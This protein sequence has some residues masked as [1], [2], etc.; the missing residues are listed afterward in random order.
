MLISSEPWWTC[1]PTAFWVPQQDGTTIQTTAAAK[2]RIHQF[3]GMSAGLVEGGTWR[4]GTLNWGTTPS[5][6]PADTAVSGTPANIE[7]GAGGAAHVRYVE[8]ADGSQSYA[9]GRI[10]KR[11][12]GTLSMT[13]YR[14]DQ[15]YSLHP[16]CQ[17]YG[18]H[19][20]NLGGYWRQYTWVEF[21]DDEIPWPTWANN[22]TTDGILF[23]QLKA[24]PHQPVLQ[25]FAKWNA[26]DRTKLDI[27]YNI[28]TTNS[29]IVVAA[30][31]ISAIEPRGVHKF[32]IDTFLDWRGRGAGGGRAYTGLWYNDQLVYT[33]T[34]NNLM[35]DV[36]DIVQP[37]WGI[38]RPEWDTKATDDCRVIF[39]LAGIKHAS[40]SLESKVFGARAARL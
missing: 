2:P 1:P 4:G 37:M 12:D 34:D 20:N 22:T 9:M 11:P 23:Y 32:C 10:I 30:H 7:S 16:R 13:Q 24:L 33:S 39:H 18:W 36:P 26:A 6:S 8:N 28:K 40:R 38:Y 17:L 15:L 35:S 21:G 14:D 3:A 31:T 25:L 5:E 29:G 19:V 27:Q